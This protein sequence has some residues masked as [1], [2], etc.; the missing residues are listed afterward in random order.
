MT[1]IKNQNKT[2]L[3]F[4][5]IFSLLAFLSP[6]SSAIFVL[7]SLMVV[8]SP[9]LLKDHKMLC[10]WIFSAC[11]MSCF[12]YQTVFLAM[13]DVAMAIFIIKTLITKPRDYKKLKFILIALSFFL[14][15]FVYS[16]VVN[17][18]AYKISQSIGI[19]LAIC[20]LYLLKKDINIKDI[21]IYLSIGLFVSSMLSLISYASGLITLKSLGEK[22]GHFFRFGG[23]FC[24]V[25]S[26]ALYC[27]LC[28][29]C[30]LYLFAINHL[31]IKKWLWLLIAITLL[32]FSSF[33]KTFI[34]ITVLTYGLAIIISFISSKNK[35]T[36]I[37]YSLILLAIG[38]LLSPII[39]KYIKIIFER[40][41]ITSNETQILNAATTG[42]M[43]IWK[44]YLSKWVS[45]PLYI[46]FGCGITA[47]NIN[48]KTPHNFLISL[49]YKF[50]IIGILILLVLLLY[51]LK[52][53]KVSK[54]PMG[55]LPLVAI[56]LNG[57]TEDLSCSLYTCLP[58]M[59]ALI[60]I[61]KNNSTIISKEN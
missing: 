44:S 28:Q 6:L 20:T 8:A 25:N 35:K 52:Q 17:G 22:E 39:I 34:L 61:L 9:L 19:V 16:C 49:L 47:P 38:I 42:R 56:I 45:S 21:I 24:N 3:Y 18:N 31:D 7:L 13:L 32:G 12:R 46:L 23:Y 43:D 2:L 26:L 27:S 53:L 58:I 14:I 29:A 59:I 33:S 41:Y 51:V 40:F 54:N 4:L 60:F 15:C 36:Y 50:G 10:F 55:Y 57:L 5:L 1:L 37:K 11:F 48:N 30:L